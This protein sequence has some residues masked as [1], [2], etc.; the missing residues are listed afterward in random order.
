KNGISLAFTPEVPQVGD[1]VFLQTTVLDSAGYPIE[2]GPVSGKIIG[3]SGRS[4]QLQF[5]PLAGGW[6]VFKA[7]FSAQEGG[8]YQI[9]VNSEKHNRKLGTTLAV[10]Q[11]QI[12]R[13]GQP[14][15]GE[16]LREIVNITR[17]ATAGVDGL[18][19]LIQ[20]MSLLP[21]PEPIERRTRLWSN[22]W[23]GGFIL[24]LLATDR[25]STRLNSSHV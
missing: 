19:E 22:P 3:P 9:E 17:G 21:E 6:G 5:S 12:E 11:P 18:Q 16:I 24:L 20:K 4:E 15:N 13:Q 14:V 2:E 10:K 7:S 23:W 8:D 1:T 25:K